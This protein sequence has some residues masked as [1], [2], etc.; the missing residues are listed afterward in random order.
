LTGAGGL[1]LARCNNEHDSKIISAPSSFQDDLTSVKLTA[2]QQLK[3]KAL[4]YMSYSKLAVPPKTGP[5]TSWVIR[6]VRVHTDMHLIASRICTVTKMLAVLV[7]TCW[8]GGYSASSHTR[9]IDVTRRLTVQTV[10][11]EPL[12]LFQFSLY[13]QLTKTFDTFE[14]VILE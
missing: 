1:D 5:L 14:G 2:F 10:I 9:P 13:V 4:A 11:L 7:S 3:R 6:V 12:S 8:K